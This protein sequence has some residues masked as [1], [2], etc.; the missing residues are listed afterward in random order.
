MRASVAF[1][2]RL[3][4]PFRFDAGALAADADALGEE[5]WERHF[6]TGYYQGDWS[7][8][9]LRSTGGRLSLY[10]D[11]SG[12]AEFT[13][14]PLLAACPN[15]AAVLAELRCPLTSVRFLRLGPG[16]RVREHTDLAL[17]FDEGEVRLHVPV[18]TGPGVEFILDGRALEMEP[19]ECWYVDVTRPHRI[20]NPGPNGRIHLVIDCVVDDRLRGLLL[21]AAA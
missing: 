16:A 18:R 1:P 7:G 11:P 21:D 12:T 8:V 3:R 10:P 19:G 17:S 4:L 13:D 5:R 9:A 6:N 14:T 20:A 2:D 15:V